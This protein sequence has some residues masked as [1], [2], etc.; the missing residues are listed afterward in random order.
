MRI[1]K[2]TPYQEKV[3]TH[4][5]QVKEDGSKETS[6]QEVLDR[7]IPLGVRSQTV[8]DYTSDQQMQE[9]RNIFYTKKAIPGGRILANG[10]GTGNQMLGNCFV[11]GITDSRQG[12]MQCQSNTFE[13]YA[14][15]GGVGTNFSPLR[16]KGA[17]VKGVQS[18]ASGPCSF[19]DAFDHYAETIKQGSSN[20]RAAKMTILNVNHPDIEEFIEAKTNHKRWKNTNVSVGITDDFMDA[21]N[22]DLNWNLTF[23]GK[24]YKTV[25]AKQVWDQLCNCAWKSAEPG[26]I[27]LDSLNRDYPLRYITELQAVNPCGELPLRD[28][29]M[30]LLL[31]LVLSSFVVDSLSAGPY[32][33]WADFSHTIKL[34]VLYMDA[35]IDYTKFPLEEIK[36]TMLDSRPIGLGITGL[37]DALFLLKLPYGNYPET[38]AFLEKLGQT[39]YETAKATSEELA[40]ELGAFPLY[41]INKADF[42][43]RRNSVLCAIAPTGSVSGLVGCSY[44]CEPHFATSII[45][46][47]SLGKDIIDN[48]IVSGWMEKHQVKELPSWARFVGG[49]LPKHTV[50]LEDHLEVLRVLA[51]YV[52]S[53]ISKTVNLPKDATVEDVSNVYMYCWKNGIKGVTVYRDGC[54]EDQPVSWSTED[55]E[56]SDEFDDYDIEV[57]DYIKNPKDWPVEAEGCVYKLKFHPEK[58]SMLIT[59]VDLEEEPLGIL[60]KVNNATHQE[61]LDGLSRSIT[62]LWRRGIRADHLFDEFSQYQSPNAFGTYMVRRDKGVMLHS[63]LHGIALVIKKHFRKLDFEGIGVASQDCIATSIS[64]VVPKDLQCPNCQEYTLK[65][66]E[67]CLTCTECGYSKCG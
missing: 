32:F 8:L 14:H 33:D 12:I 6:L 24:V 21:V 49:S 22:G 59:I 67:G 46:D 64:E 56:D 62:S 15:G 38:L 34:M 13:I 43:Q 65:R 53:S 20:R 36:A 44:G 66:V 47:E 54:R 39:L 52:D 30:C 4:Y 27:F 5:I 29:E 35:L 3:L 41:D 1:T 9:F 10:G 23:E 17:K 45:R 55:I 28:N 18:L 61:Y 37:A 7:I 50:K 48:L 63:I 19:I 31:S 11:Q 40:K 42:P 51:Q 16:P 26:V 58:P 25:K 2:L 57:V 60:F